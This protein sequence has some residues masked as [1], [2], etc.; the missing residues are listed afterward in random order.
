MGRNH[1]VGIILAAIL[2][3]ALYQGGSEVSFEIP[4]LTRDMIVVIQGMII[5]MCGALENVFRPYLEALFRP[6]RAAMVR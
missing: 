3:G 4:T 6:R 5:L 2:F 1:P